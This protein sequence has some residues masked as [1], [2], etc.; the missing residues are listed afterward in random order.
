MKIKEQAQTDGLDIQPNREHKS[1]VF[2]MLFSNPDILRELYSA[3]EGVNLPPDIP[4]NV[5]TL[6][7]ALIKGKLNDVSFIIDNR[8][9]VLIEHQSTLNENMPLRIL[10]YIEK[11]YKKTI[12]YANA[13]NEKLIKIPKPEFIVL[14]N[15]EKPYPEKGELRLSDAFMD[16]EGLARDKDR[17]SLELV[18][19]VYNINHGHNPEIQQ[20]CGTLNNYSFFI[21]KIREYQ[22]TGLTLAKSIECA[23]RY[24][25]ENNILKDFLKEHGSQVGSLLFYEY[26][27]DT[28]MKVIREEGIEEGIEIGEHRGGQKKQEYVLG[29]IAQ[30][31]TAEEIKQR[32]EQRTTAQLPL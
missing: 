23:I 17:I 11:V 29:L 2:S 31:L 27:F 21:N 7:N 26:D 32:L 8:L 10:E 9:V 15:G 14:Y 6:S 16:I 19:Q 13:Y 12:D 25:I 28:H 1:S 20:K 3:I 4:I 5:N 30:G 24:C 22:R 18:V